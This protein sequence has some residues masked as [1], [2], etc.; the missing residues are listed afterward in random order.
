MSSGQSVPIK[1]EPRVNY[2]IEIEQFERGRPAGLYPDPAVCA[3]DIDY[4]AERGVVTATI[5]NVGSK[6]LQ[7]LT[8]DFYE[9]NPESGGRKIGS[10]VIAELEAPIDLEPRAETLSVSCKIEGRP[11]DIYVVLDAA[12]SV[13]DEITTFNNVA[14]ATLPRPKVEPP[15]QKLKV[16]TGRGR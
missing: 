8:V 3:E 5:H 4:D 1:V 9:G 13:E 15:K 16:S 12:D 10:Q 11:M 7:N 14:Q 6:S 2:V